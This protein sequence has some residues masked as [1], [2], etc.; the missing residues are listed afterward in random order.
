MTGADTLRS[1]GQRGGAGAGSVP[2]SPLQKGSA[3]RPGCSQRE[4][5]ARPRLGD[6]GVGFSSALD[7][8]FTVTAQSPSP[9]TRLRPVPVPPGGSWLGAA[10]SFGTPLCSMARWVPVPFLVTN[11]ASW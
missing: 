7:T 8:G 10:T 1:S 2:A 5:P 4:I 6:S 9:G 11:E 3:A